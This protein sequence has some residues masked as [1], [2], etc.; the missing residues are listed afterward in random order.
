MDEKIFTYGNKCF[1]TEIVNE[2][3]KSNRPKPEKVNFKFGK[4]RVTAT[5]AKK[6]RC[7]QD[8]TAIVIIMENPD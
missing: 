6:M 1:S 2:K 7:Y 5:N 8:G 3:P 4:I